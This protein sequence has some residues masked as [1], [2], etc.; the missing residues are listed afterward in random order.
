VL[1]ADDPA[2]VRR[3]LAAAYAALASAHDC[4]PARKAA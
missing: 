2:A 3:H 4:E 1:R